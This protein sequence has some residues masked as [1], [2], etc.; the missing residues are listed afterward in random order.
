MK[1]ILI[2]GS[3]TGIGLATAIEYAKQGHTI[4]MACR[5]LVKAESAAEQVR[6]A[7]ANS[8][9][10]FKLDLSD[11]SLVKGQV[12]TILAAFPHIDVLI[13]NAGVFNNSKQLTAQGFEGQFG[14]NAL[15]AV[16]FTELLLPTIIQAKG[17]VIHL[18][19]MAH[20]IGRIN[21]ST[22]KA[23]G[24]YWAILAY[25]QSKLGNL[26][27]SD[28]LALR[29]KGTGATS[30][31]IHPGGVYSDLYRKFNPLVR[32]FLKVIL[33]APSVPAKKLL[34]MGV[35]EQWQNKN[36]EYVAVQPIGARSAIASKIDNAT[37]FE[38][39]ALELIAP[40]L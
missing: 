4:I 12:A 2:T 9:H 26:L 29:L 8:V 23:E 27:Y 39:T 35:S 13:N 22:F 31:A 28:A 20:L 18:A 37:A 40:Y 10:V 25:A 17:R 33:I 14:V 6:A 7:G 24:R 38:A 11:L 30:N 1:N 15:G 19:S 34:E 16:L 3:N 32:G 5:D 36:G 21:Q